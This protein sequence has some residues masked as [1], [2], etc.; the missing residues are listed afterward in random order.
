M[1]TVSKLKNRFRSGIFVLAA[2]SLSAVNSAQALSDE[3]R[4][5]RLKELKITIEQLQSELKNIRSDRSD[6][7][8]NLEESETKIS[9]LSKKVKALQEQL[10]DRQ[11]QL[12]QLKSEKEALARA[13]KQQTGSVER[14]INAAYRLGRQSTLKLL[15][16]QQDPAHVARNLHYF[17]HIVSA[18]TEQIQGYI[19]TLDRLEKIEPEIKQTAGILSRNRDA[20]EAKRQ[21]LLGKFADRKRTLAQLES[22]LSNKDEELASL[23]KDRKH[24]ESLLQQVVMVTGDLD[25]NVSNRSFKELKGKLPWPTKGR[26]LERFGSARVQNKVNWEGLVIGA[27]QGA[28]VHAV[29]HGRVVFADYLRGH[30]LLLIIDHGDDYLSLYAHNEALY[31]DIG[32]WVS[33]GEQIATVG[34]SGGQR[35]I[36]LYFELRYQGKPTNPQH[37]LK[38]SA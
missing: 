19:R 4:Q 6:L 28:S 16:N 29:H 22:T 26:V 23:E 2:L 34:Q 30:G 20:L 32:D 31:K 8:N 10:E 5:A 9:E 38:K 36:G 18:Q 24:L 14:H 37:W 7:L 11:S 13:K 3:E 17:D 15:L 25:I 12:N 35:Q 21:E 1:V 33:A 27:E